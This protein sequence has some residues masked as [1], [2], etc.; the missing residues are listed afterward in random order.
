MVGTLLWEV[1]LNLLA[2]LIGHW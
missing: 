2:R 1:A